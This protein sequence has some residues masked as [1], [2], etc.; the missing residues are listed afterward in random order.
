MKSP[1]KPRRPYNDAN[2]PH[3]QAL[4]DR[5]TTGNHLTSLWLLVCLSTVVGGWGNQNAAWGQTPVSLDSLPP[6]PEE[7]KRWIDAG[8]VRFQTGTS[9]NG[10]AASATESEQASNHSPRR[11][12]DD[13]RQRVGLAAKTEYQIE[14]RCDLKTSWQWNPTSRELLISASL[15]QLHWQPVHTVWF[16]KLPDTE[17]F[18]THR[19][20]L[21]E[22]DHVRLSCDPGMKARFA[23]SLKPAIVIR[24]KLEVGQRI[25]PPLIDQITNDY[26]QQRFAEIIELID[27]RYLEL[28]RAT[29]HGR[30]PLR[31]ASPLY[32]LLRETSSDGGAQSAD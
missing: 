1:S 20:V 15:R 27:L 3:P 26:L 28:D 16:R 24:H 7:L 30:S 8:Q 18:W 21:H 10:Q 19:L 22:F 11:D 31:K 13:D 14:F 17:N 4:I 2:H 12:L 29:G 9:D 6:A 32:E 23:A 5:M 25:S